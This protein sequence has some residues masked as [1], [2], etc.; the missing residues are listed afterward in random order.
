MEYRLDKMRQDE[1]GG[2]FQWVD[3]TSSTGSFVIVM[4][5]EAVDVVR[6]FGSEIFIDR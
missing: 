6:Q 1:P 4:R 3:A 2:L 5:Q